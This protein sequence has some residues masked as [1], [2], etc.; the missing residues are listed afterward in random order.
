MLLTQAVEGAQCIEAHGKF[1]KDFVKKLKTKVTSAKDNGGLHS[2]R[3]YKSAKA[4]LENHTYLDARLY[5]LCFTDSTQVAP[6]KAA[7]KAL[8]ERLRDYNMPCQ[9]KAALEADDSKD[10][11]M[12]VFLLVEAKYADPNLTIN[13]KDG[14]LKTMVQMKG[15][16]FFLNHPRDP[17]HFSKAGTQ[18]LYATLPRSKP[19]KVADCLEWISYLYKNRSKPKLRQ[20]Y[21]SSRPTRAITSRPQGENVGNVIPQS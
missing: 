4:M 18:K 10:L 20:I 1:K 15:I 17:I 6:Y 5:H 16:G 12:H 8:V 14:W 19:D 9:Y 3:Q 21:F 2:T 11:H 7:I 13:R